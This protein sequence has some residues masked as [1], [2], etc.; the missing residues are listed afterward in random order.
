M[1]GRP[2]YGKVEMRFVVSAVGFGH[3][4]GLLERRL[5]AAG[6]DEVRETGPKQVCALDAP[7]PRR[8]VPFPGTTGSPSPH[9]VL[10]AAG[11]SGGVPAKGDQASAPVGRAR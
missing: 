7:D 6:P 9:V 11:A 8:G 2:Q 10:A 5:L 4:S 3:V 1:C